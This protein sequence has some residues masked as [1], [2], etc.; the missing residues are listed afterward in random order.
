MKENEPPSLN[1]KSSSHKVANNIWSS[2][3]K[4]LSLPGPSA[5]YV[6]SKE[7][8]LPAFLTASRSQLK[9]QHQDHHHFTYQKK[10]NLSGYTELVCFNAFLIYCVL[11]TIF[12]YYTDVI[13]LLLYVCII[14]LSP[15]SNFYHTLECE[16]FKQQGICTYCLPTISYLD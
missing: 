11:Y 7:L 3:L 8:W 6:L 16:V 2:S 13:Y 1:W 5:C 10:K 15:M 9:C 4:I 12:L 14:D